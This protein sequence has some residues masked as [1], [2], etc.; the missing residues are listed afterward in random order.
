MYI[1]RKT[2]AEKFLFNNKCLSVTEAR[3]LLDLCVYVYI[4]ASVCI[5]CAFLLVSALLFVSSSFKTHTYIM[6]ITP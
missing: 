1:S 2:S 3:R 6:I 5:N 4:Q